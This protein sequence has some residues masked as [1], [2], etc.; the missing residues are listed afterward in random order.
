MAGDHTLDKVYN[1]AYSVELTP[2]P[3][4]ILTFTLTTDANCTFELRNDTSKYSVLM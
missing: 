3:V 2:A 1:V 4:D